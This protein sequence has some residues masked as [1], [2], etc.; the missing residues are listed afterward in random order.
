MELETL[1]QAIRDALQP[2]LS[3]T[4]LVI[5]SIDALLELTAC[6]VADA[7]MLLYTL[8]QSLPMFSRLVVLSAVDASRDAQ[9]VTAA[10]V[11][12]QLWSGQEPEDLAPGTTWSHAT[13]RARVHPPA[14]LR[15]LHA[16]YGL[17]PPTSSAGLRQA[18]YAEAGKR[19]PHTVERKAD[20]R[21][22][23]VLHSVGGRGPLGIA[24]EH[25][26][27]NDQ[28]T[29]RLHAMDA[30]AA[31]HEP[32][33]SAEQ[34]LGLHSDT[35]ELYNTGIG[36]LELH[37][38]LSSGKHVEEL[39][40]C[41]YES[42]ADGGARLR[43]RALDMDSGTLFPAAPPADPHASMVQQLPFNLGETEQQRQ[44]R[45]QVALPYTYQLHDPPASDTAWRGST[46]KSAIFFEPESEDDEDEDDP[47]DDL[48]V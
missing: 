37:A 35:S 14:L 22:W 36:F 38:A 17:T 18:A 43:L 24:E 26:W 40:G 33:L 41:A 21:F 44:R 3:R 25:G 5:D 32:Q 27:W 15:H 46:G 48:D 11:A 31:P 9:A 4:M 16:S 39:A 7:Y 28:R 10:L 23:S 8:L 30:C 20:P 47:D 6:S 45:E 13:I 34:V 12:P 19:A 42:Q 29:S 1:E 2:T